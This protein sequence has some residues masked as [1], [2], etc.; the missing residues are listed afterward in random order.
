MTD[1]GRRELLRQFGARVRAR[2]RARGLSQEALA[3]RAGCSIARVGRIE[4]GE[5]DTGITAVYALA[6]AL[7]VGIDELL[8]EMEGGATAP[9]PPT[10]SEWQ[11]VS[12]VSASLARTAE[13]MIRFADRFAHGA[14]RRKRSQR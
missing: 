12:E 10:G 5:A 1:A 2:R 9:E 14:P 3:D 6:R 8:P 13:E 4:R 11:R 7:D